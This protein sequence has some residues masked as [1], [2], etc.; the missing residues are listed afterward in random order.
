MSQYT[1]PVSIELQVPMDTETKG[2]AEK[3]TEI[4]IEDWLLSMQS[5]GYIEGYSLDVGR[6]VNDYL[7]LR[8]VSQDTKVE[9]LGAM[10]N[11]LDSVSFNAE[12]Q[13][14]S[15]YIAM[16]KNLLK[17]NPEEAN[18]L[19]K[20]SGYMVPDYLKKSIPQLKP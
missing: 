6:E 17:N 9:A 16:S 20:R 8:C 7:K 1:I 11:V 4:E 18:K 3:E 14:R 10:I 12:G 13:P 15:Q 5:H 19:S 2:E